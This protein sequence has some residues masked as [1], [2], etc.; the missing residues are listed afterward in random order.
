M[1][2][3][4]GA[5]EAGGVQGLGDTDRFGVD[6]VPVEPGPVLVEVEAGGADQDGLGAEL[7]HAEGDVGADAAPAYVEVVDQ[8]GERNRVQ[9]VRDELVGE[10]AGE[11]HEMVGGDGAGDCDAHDGILL[12]K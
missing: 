5:H 12:R 4:G 6:A 2:G 1:V 9:P 10:A 3:V 8:E 7:A 11:G